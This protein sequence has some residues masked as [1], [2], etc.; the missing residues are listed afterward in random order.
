MDDVS[1]PIPAP[2]V[3]DLTERTGRAL[4]NRTLQPDELDRLLSRAER[5]RQIDS[6]GLF[7]ALGVLTVF[8]GVVLLY[9]VNYHSMGHQDKRFTPF[10]FPAVLLITAVVL[11]RRGRP[12]WEIELCSM[13]ADLAVGITFLA[14]ARAWGGGHDYGLAAGVISLAISI[15]MYRLVRLVRLTAWA[16]AA[17]IVA[18]TGFAFAHSTLHSIAEWA[19][20]DAGVAAVIGLLLLTR[21]RALGAQALYLS[22][23][24]ALFAGLSGVAADA[25]NEFGQPVVSIWAGELFATTLLALVAAAVLE[26]TG[27]LWLGAL[28]ALLTLAAVV[29]PTRGETRWAYLM[30]A[31]GVGLA[32]V[33]TLIHRNRRLLHHPTDRQSIGR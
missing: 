3:L 32:V 17:A 9:V 28:G 8:A 7:R 19:I 5:R 1:T 24:L 29:E 2:A 15:A 23:M 18:I 21:S 31:I 16:A 11:D 4:E 27:L 14:A 10:L 22:T 33:G 25:F 13:V 30:M 6:G 12:H 20:A 26:L